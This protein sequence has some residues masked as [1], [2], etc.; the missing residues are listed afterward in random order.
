MPDKDTTSCKGPECPFDPIQMGK[1]MQLA[2]DT[3][4]Q[5]KS[6]DAKVTLQNSRT[7]KLEV[8]MATKVEDTEIESKFKTIYKILVSMMFIF[9]FT[10]IAF[11]DGQLWN[12][13]KTL[14]P[15]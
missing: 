14:N 1:L 12:A 7:T 15:F 2:E 10:I 11:H 6:I 9:L 5:V 13:I 3:N 4:A 8:A